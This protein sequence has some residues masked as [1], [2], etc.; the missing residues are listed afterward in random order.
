VNATHTLFSL[1]PL[2]E[3]APRAFLAYFNFHLPSQEASPPTAC[4]SERS[5]KLRNR[6]VIAEV[7]VKGKGIDSKSCCFFMGSIK[8]I[9][10][11]F[12]D[13]A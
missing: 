3:L 5:P 12:L 2:T 8:L 1:F 9:P 11:V 10:L 6:Q 13:A 7:S 4:Y